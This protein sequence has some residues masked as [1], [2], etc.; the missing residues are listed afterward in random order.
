MIGLVRSTVS[1]S[2]SSMRRSTPWVLGCC[3][4]ML[5]II[6]SSSDGPPLDRA[7]A[8]SASDRRSTAP[9]SRSSSSAPAEPRERHL[10]GALG[11]LD[12]RAAAWSSGVASSGVRR[13]P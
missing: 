2:S 1:P 8:A 6:V 10:L 12:A 11:G 5:M 9:S 3:G 7:S 13:V 4:P